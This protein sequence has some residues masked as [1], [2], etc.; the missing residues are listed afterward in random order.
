VDAALATAVE[1]DELG[2]PFEAAVADLHRL[3]LTP[4]QC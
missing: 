3:G 4:R 1:L 2:E